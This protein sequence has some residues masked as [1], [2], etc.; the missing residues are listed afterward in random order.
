MATVALAVGV[1]ENDVEVRE[2]IEEALVLRECKPQAL[3]SV[4]E[5]LAFASAGGAGFMIVDLNMGQGRGTEGLEV[6]ERVKQSR[7]GIQIC[8]YSQHAKSAFARR[9]QQVGADIILPKSLNIPGD[10]ETIM[11]AFGHA[12]AIEYEQDFDEPIEVVETDKRH[13]LRVRLTY[14]GRSVPIPEEDPWKDA[15]L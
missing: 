3:N 10:M 11:A 2:K 5:A 13:R 7:P 15:E 14:R 4:A 1:M 9:A 12:Q 6:I 8:L